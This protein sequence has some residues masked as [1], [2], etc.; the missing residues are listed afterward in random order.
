MKSLLSIGVIGF[1]LVSSCQKEELSSCGNLNK[2][3]ADKVEFYQAFPY[4]GPRMKP[5]LDL[6]SHELFVIDLGKR[7]SNSLEK[8]YNPLIQMYL[9]K[10]LKKPFPKNQVS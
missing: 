8:I 2:S 4:T 7:I 6:K 3:L 5:I 10:L 1:L 9:S